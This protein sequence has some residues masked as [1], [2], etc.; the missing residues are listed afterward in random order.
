M[1]GFLTPLVRARTHLRLAYLLLGLP[2]G[3]FYFV[4][5]VTALS[6]GVGL[7]IIWVGVPILLAAVVTWRGMGSFE[8]R[9]RKAGWWM[10][11][12]ATLG[13]V[14][15]VFAGNSGAREVGIFLLP[16]SSK[17]D[18]RRRQTPSCCNQCRAISCS[19]VSSA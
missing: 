7:V 16:I 10:L 4:F 13:G 5:L 1:D 14:W 18:C 2:F 9:F 6:V 12:A 17:A 3:I 8:R 15:F 19:V 11:W